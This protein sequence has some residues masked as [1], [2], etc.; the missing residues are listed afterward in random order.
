MKSAI[1]S[2]PVCVP[3]TRRKVDGRQSGK[4][5]SWVLRHIKSNDLI[6]RTWSEESSGNRR[7]SQIWKYCWRIQQKG[8]EKSRGCFAMVTQRLDFYS[9]KRRRSQEKVSILLESWLFEAHFVFQSNPGTFWRYCYWSWDHVGNVSEVHSIIR[10][11]LIS[12]AQSLKR[13]R[14]SVFFTN[15]EPDGR[16]QLYGGNL[17]R[18]DKAKAC[19][20]QE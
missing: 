12:G 2:T 4:L 16:W 13:G 17:V 15:M 6:A 1:T 11:G 14:Q 18:L 3:L 7:S 20:I 10:S 19:S 5:W 9:G 8:K